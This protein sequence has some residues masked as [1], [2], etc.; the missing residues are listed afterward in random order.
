MQLKIEV[1]LSWIS[2]SLEFRIVII[3]L[4][5]LPIRM[6]MELYI[7]NRNKKD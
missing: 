1:V 7:F 2:V 3:D 5:T 4:E 6:L